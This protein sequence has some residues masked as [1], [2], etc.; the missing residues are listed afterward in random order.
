VSDIALAR[1]VEPLHRPRDISDPFEFA[2]TRIVPALGAQ[3]TALRLPPLYFTVAPLGRSSSRPRM[4]IQLFR[5]DQPVANRT[6]VLY[7]DYPVAHVLLSAGS[8]AAPTPGDYE[9]RLTVEQDRA[10]VQR[11]LR[12]TLVNP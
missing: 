8:K 11:S 3:P 9:V 1:Q 6:T 7:E 12:F 10:R 2:E 5:N 4:H